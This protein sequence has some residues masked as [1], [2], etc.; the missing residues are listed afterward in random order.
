MQPL[1]EHDVGRHVMVQVKLTHQPMGFRLGKLTK[2]I[3]APR[4][5]KLYNFDVH[6]VG[7]KGARGMKL[8]KDG[9]TTA[10]DASAGTHAPEGTWFFVVKAT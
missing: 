3:T 8:E 5:V 9:K 2:F 10:Y 4:F 6:F 1:T 7:E